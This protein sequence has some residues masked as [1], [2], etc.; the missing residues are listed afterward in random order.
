M[1]VQDAAVELT[2]VLVALDTV[3]PTLVPG[4]PGERA[5]VELLA[6]RLE[7]RGF[8]LEVVGP[9]ERPSLIRPGR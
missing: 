9:A 4:A 7:P 2:R 1:D 3:N 6:A 8:E 5:A